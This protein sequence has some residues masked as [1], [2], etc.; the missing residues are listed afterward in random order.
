MQ[1]TAI[2]CQRID[3]SVGKGRSF[4]M[5][6]ASIKI[7]R[8]MKLLAIFLL[9]LCLQV[10]AE[11]YAQVI[12]L[13]AQNMPLKKMFGEIE[14]QSGYS[15]FYSDD[16]LKN[17][18]TVTIR[19]QN[20]SLGQVL[21][22]IFKEQPLTY[23][24]VDKTIVV[25]EKKEN[26]INTEGPA[27]YAINIKGR[28]LNE[29]DEPVAGATVAV[30][31]TQKATATNDNGEFELKDVDEN[32]TLLFSGVNIQNHEVKLNGRTEL[33]VV[34]VKT[35][36]VAGEEVQVIST[37]YQQIRRERLTGAVATIN[38]ATYHQSISV[39][40][41]FL[42]N[43]EGR[44]PGLV[45][46]PNTGNS[47]GAGLTIRGIST[48]TA[49]MKPLIILNGFP[50]EMDLDNIDP[51][52]IE[53]ITVLK[54]AAAAAIYGVRSS[55]GVIIIA[56]KKGRAGAPRFQFTS[57]VTGQSLP[58]FSY[59]QYLSGADFVLAERLKAD[60]N[61]GSGI[62]KTY[63][64][65]RNVSYTPVFGANDDLKN[66]KITQAQADAIFSQYA[67]YDNTADYTRLFLQHPFLKTAS[68]NVSGG[69][70]NAL[71]LFGVSYQD[72]DLVQRL[73]GSN[74]TTVNYRGSFKVLKRINLD[75]QSYYAN[76]K[77]QSA[78]SPAYSDFRPYQR[79][80]DDQGNPVPAY[81]QQ[82]NTINLSIPFS[83]S[84]NETKAINAI[85]KGLY[86]PRYYPYQELTGTESK[87]LTNVY[88][89]QGKLTA[90][91]FKGLELELGGQYEKQWSVQNTIAGEQAF[92]TRMALNLY[93]AADPTSGKPVF[94][95]P[96]GGVKYTTNNTLTS[97]TLRGQFV[98]NNTFGR[99]AVT[100][101]LG[102][103]QRKIITESNLSTAFGYDPNTI[104]YKPVNL[105]LFNGQAYSTPFVNE[106]APT[107]GFYGGYSLSNFF[108]ETFL[109]N[110][111]VSSYGNAAYTYNQ[112]YTA[113]GSF[114]IDQSN[115]F[116]TDPKFRYVPLWSAG[117]L[118][119]VGK[120]SFLN[121]VSWLNKLNIRSSI[122]YN[123][124]TASGAGPFTTLI[125]SNNIFAQPNPIGSYTI[126]TPVNNS[127]RWEKTFIYNMGL[128][129]S[130][131]KSRI[132]GT[133]D[134]YVK[135]SRDLIEMM[136][137]D[138]TTGGNGTGV[139]A[140]NASIRN[141]GFEVALN[142]LNIQ[143]RNF[144]WS[145]QVTGSFNNNKL[146]D[147]N[148]MFNLN[149]IDRYASNSSSTKILGYPLSPL[150]A[151]A[152]AGLNAL[153]QP[154]VYDTSGKA[155]VQKV[156]ALLP[157]SAAKYM[158]TTIPKYVIGLNNQFSFYN[159]DV[160][161][162][163]MYYGGHTGYIAP[164]TLD[165]DRPLEG[166]LNYWKKPGDELQTNYPGFIVTN[167]A[168]PRAFDGLALQT[169]TY[170]DM[171]FK[172]MDYI[173]VRNITLAYNLSN[174]AKKWGLDN[175]RIRLQVQNPWKYVFNG[176]HIDPETMNLKTGT[177][178]V[179]VVKSYTF[180]ISTNF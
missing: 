165:A 149:R 179:P 23:S 120:E 21:E 58:D 52:D 61:A 104:G 160:N 111:F 97:H 34:N 27:P 43:L 108:S 162:L 35:K 29:Q 81:F 138:P 22:T 1:L 153:G 40:G 60:F 136:S 87:I 110:R 103:E 7:L 88:H 115:L 80:V 132:S 167:T 59:H 124:N 154:T 93:T 91:L 134:Y 156:T 172:K 133:L 105:T 180:S 159:L 77:T 39:A 26:K 161:I 106:F 62:T 150:F 143:Q 129:F 47:K 144:S 127:L 137:I 122:G 11:G 95:Y 173:A 141:R 155:V 170:A 139:V 56:T 76:G 169:Y 84:V 71:Y 89:F 51:T 142:T 13:S 174:L 67:S 123:G 8:I 45:Y 57:A 113:T 114:R 125:F 79:F 54:D 145:T 46:N 19:V 48:L 4:R 78:P 163:L 102:A 15:F 30:K 83:Q 50:T 25:K 73:N 3:Q 12:N 32:A 140:N 166:A 44:I 36:I 118:W 17:A 151:Y 75:I 41:N 96:Q 171:F 2:S 100:A 152:Y 55:N 177:R 42:A 85:S 20:A 68:L 31:G 63:F 70:D 116:G 94:Q 109:D 130:V 99:H 69:S 157:V 146:T 121:K 18:K 98:Y 10:S 92:E 131:S 176:E 14:K 24:I 128:D 86:D 72:N 5:H 168:D 119:A 101:L 37:G 65:T 147:L 90:K 126:N 16:D 9:S 135:D 107:G 33:A 28:V 112:K 117:V 74:R 6:T 82:R 64:D 38:S 164:P 53:S 175:T 178:S 158:G 66:N 148:F 49:D